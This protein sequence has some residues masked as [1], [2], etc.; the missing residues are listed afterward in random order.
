MSAGSPIFSSAENPE[1]ASAI[2]DV[3]LAWTQA[4]WELVG[5]MAAM[6]GVSHTKASSLYH[7]IS[8]F[9]GRTQALYALVETSEGFDGLKPFIAKF[10]KLSKRRNEIVHGLYISEFGTDKLYRAKM[11]ESHDHPRRS[12]QTKPNDIAQHAQRV[13]EE[14]ERL[15]RDGKNI[16]GYIAWLKPHPKETE[17]PHPPTAPK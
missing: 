12:V 14:C 15:R 1:L 16:P 6:L 9:H 17:G 10:S 13:R 11:D 7:Q 8:N 2:G 3:I 4:E 5:M